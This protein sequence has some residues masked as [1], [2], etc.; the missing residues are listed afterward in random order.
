MDELDRALMV[1]FERAAG[2]LLSKGRDAGEVARVVG[3]A[4]SKVVS[5]NLRSWSLVLRACDG[6]IPDDAGLGAVSLTG[7]KVKAWCGPVAIGGAGVSLDEAAR[8]FGVNRTT[9]SRWA[10]PEMEPESGEG[11]GWGAGVTRGRTAQSAAGPAHCGR[12]GNRKRVT[13]KQAVERQIALAREASAGDRFGLPSSYRVVGR[14]L[15]LDYTLNRSNRKRDVVRVWTPYAYGVDPGGEVWSAD[16][17]WVRRR[18]VELVPSGFSQSLMRVDRRLSAKSRVWQWVCPVGD[19]GCGRRVYKLFL[20]MPVW[21]LGAALW[22]EAEASRCRR[23]SGFYQGVS[24]VGCFD[25]ASSADG[26]MLEDDWREAGRRE[27]WG[28]F[29]CGRCCRLVYESSERRSSPGVRRDGSRRRVDVW[30]RFVKRISG[31]VLSGGEVVVRRGG[32]G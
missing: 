11:V 10:D 14:R 3:R 30:D 8:L 32:V 23:P 13:W 24:E 17:G 20:P 1:G 28:A 26:L 9:V 27:A 7:A 12:G 31:G 25:A 19:G 2:R 5:G 22:S 21:T 15:M 4:S 18:L 16:W 6:R 29:L